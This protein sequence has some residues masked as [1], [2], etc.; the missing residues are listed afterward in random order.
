MIF[1]I[2]SLA[3]E[4]HTAEGPGKLADMNLFVGNEK[5]HI[6]PVDSI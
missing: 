2:A 6:G 5:L 3:F 4:A 1:A